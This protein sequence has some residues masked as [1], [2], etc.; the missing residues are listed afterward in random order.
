MSFSFELLAKWGN[1]RAGVMHTPHGDVP[2]P[3]FMPVGTQASIK[4]LDAFD[5]ISTRAP[6]M[7]ANT[8]HLYLRPGEEV[9]NK[10]GGVQNM[11][12]W[13]KPVLTDSGGFQ[14]FSLGEQLKQ[15]KKGK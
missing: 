6:I 1:A 14:V 3:I 11:M 15:K 7:L 9:V 13:N 8:Y 10:L 5:V 12:Q 4:A 2:T